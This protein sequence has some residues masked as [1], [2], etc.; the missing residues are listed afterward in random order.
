MIPTQIFRQRP[1]IT[2]NSTMASA[3]SSSPAD[4]KMISN[5][6]PMA[7]VASQH[8]CGEDC[9]FKCPHPRIIDGNSCLVGWLV[10]ACTWCPRHLTHDLPR[11]SQVKHAHC[12]P[13][14]HGDRHR[15]MAIMVPHSWCQGIQQ[16]AN[17]L[18]NR[19]TLLKLEYLIFINTN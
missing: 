9:Y 1:L 14:N 18:H 8:A 15:P 3:A 13:M 19:A 7:Q 10:V 16:S 2:R 12:T 4:T 5:I 6:Y 17:M 11:K